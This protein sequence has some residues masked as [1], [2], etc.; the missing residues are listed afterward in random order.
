MIEEISDAI[1]RPVPRETYDRLEQFAKLLLEANQRQ[2]L[3]AQASI[4]ELWSRH[5]L[6]GAQLLGRAK[7]PGR[8]CDIGSG[9]GLPGLVVAILGGTPMTLI[10][11]RRLRAEFLERTIC[12]LQLEQVRVAAC[13]AEAVADKFDIIT[14]RAVARLDRLFSLASHLAHPETLW[15]LPK[16]ESVKSELDEAR[17]TW[18]GEFEMVPS[19]THSQAAIVVARNVRQRGK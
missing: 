11:P 4:P 8:W 2:N 13:K 7:E 1:G 14:A 17:L 18:Q 10:E 16:G 15:L 12:Q 5:I 6:D 3:I 9:A 19:R